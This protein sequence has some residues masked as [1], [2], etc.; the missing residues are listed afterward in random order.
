MATRTRKLRNETARLNGTLACPRGCG[1]PR[2]GR[3]AE[4]WVIF[5]DQEDHYIEATGKTRSEAV[6]RWRKLER[7]KPA[8]PVPGTLVANWSSHTLLHGNPRI[9]RDRLKGLA[10]HVVQMM[11]EQIQWHPVTDPISRVTVTMTA[12]PA[13]EAAENSAIAEST[14]ESAL[15][16]RDP[17]TES[18]VSKK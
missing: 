3:E 11:M 6:T 7:E 12:Q 2:F 17:T 14:Q 18:C 13:I 16:E 15:P 9:V 8:L 4:G 1:E 5:C 10:L